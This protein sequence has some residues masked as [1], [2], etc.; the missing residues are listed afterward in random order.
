MKTPQRRKV[1]RVLS[2]LIF[3]I[4]IMVVS[5]ISIMSFWAI[6]Q[7]TG[8]NLGLTATIVPFILLGLGII[9]SA[10]DAWRRKYT[11]TNQVEE[12]LK[13]TEEITNGN[14]NI[15]LNPLHDYGK[16]DDFDIIKLNIVKMARELDKNEILK[17]DFISN[18]SHEIKTPL[19]II[20]NSATMLMSKNLSEKEKQE[21][22]KSMN[23]TVTKLTNLI[24]NI[25]KLNKLEHQQIGFEN[26][27]FDLSELV[28]ESVIEFES[29]IEKKNLKLNLDI[30]DI[31]LKND[32]SLF[33][34]IINNL[35]S[36]AIKFTDENGKIDI[37]LKRENSNVILSVKDNGI[38]MDS[39]TGLKIFEKFYQGDTSHRE[40]GNGLGLALVKNVINIIGGEITVES[41]IGKGS[42]FIV[43]VKG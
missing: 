34:I 8:E 16:Y 15:K 36:N 13:A 25:L 29:L 20:R 42:K 10:V 14:F 11:V 26:I 27:D 43:K 7:S 41:E 21:Y 22:L 24:S 17:S 1:P 4:P 5:T 32:S 6:Y 40:Q 39:E 33:E 3:T 23:N 31:T 2:I 38:G 18:L 30:E 37:S 28:R 12:I 19:A 35:I 9:C